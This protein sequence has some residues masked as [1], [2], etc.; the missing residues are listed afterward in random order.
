VARK[1]LTH[2]ISI[3]RTAAEEQ[4][5]CRRRQS[6]GR[7]RLSRVGARAPQALLH[8]NKPALKHCLLRYILPS[9]PR[10]VVATLP[11]EVY[12]YDSDA[13]GLDVWALKLMIEKCIPTHEGLKGLAEA[14]DSKIAR[15]QELLAVLASLEPP[16][17]RAPAQDP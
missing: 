16:T 8:R 12:L 14:R 3:D 10:D 13:Y 4:S 11:L 1:A 5:R 17:E 6:I 2:E 15:L 7:A 9:W